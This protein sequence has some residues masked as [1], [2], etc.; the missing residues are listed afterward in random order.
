[1]DNQKARPAKEHFDEA[2]RIWKRTI[3]KTNDPKWINYA[4]K[5]IERAEENIKKLVI[6]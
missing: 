5:G 1:M 3:T 4:Q 6:W 2:I